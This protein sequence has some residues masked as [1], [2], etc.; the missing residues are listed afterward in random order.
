MLILTYLCAR[1]AFW[2]FV[3]D[4]LN[5]NGAV[6]TCIGRANG[7]WFLI[8]VCLFLFNFTFDDV[9]RAFLVTCWR[10]LYENPEIFMTSIERCRRSGLNAFSV[11]SHAYRQFQNMIPRCWFLKIL[12]TSYVSSIVVF[13]IQ[14]KTAMSTVVLDA[15][16][17]ADSISVLEYVIIPVWW[18]D[19]GR[20][21][22]SFVVQIFKSS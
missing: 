14:L 22:M 21:L 3:R 12:S 16:K 18:S 17:F 13:Q 5:W 6:H 7:R 8:C 15:P 2:R 10:H 1:S 4:T 9:H 19:V 11:H 20:M